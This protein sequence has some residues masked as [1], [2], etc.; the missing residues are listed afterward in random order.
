MRILNLNHE[1]LKTRCLPVNEVDELVR[2]RLDIM[3]EAMEKAGGIGLSANQVGFFN[4]MFVM[5]GSDDKRYNI[6]NPELVWKGDEPAS[7]KEGCLSLPG[8]FVPIKNRKREVLINF[9]DIDG[10]RQENVLF[11][12][13]DAICVQHEMEHL[14]GKSFLDHLNRADRRLIMRKHL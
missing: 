7:L 8:V 11:T 4:A 1:A 10:T 9:T 5:K 12:D 2:L 13:V 14:Q 6:I 3:W